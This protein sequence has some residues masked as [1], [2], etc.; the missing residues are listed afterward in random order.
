MRDPRISV[1]KTV[2]IFIIETVA[3]LFSLSLSLSL[4]LFG[5]WWVVGQ[6]F[7]TLTQIQSWE[8]KVIRVCGT[9]S[10]EKKLTAAL[11]KILVKES[12]SL[13]YLRCSSEECVVEPPTPSFHLFI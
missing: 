3:F 11:S 7:P 10:A 5:A 4:S 8:K 6:G 2:D 1:A 9:R 13:G 12:I